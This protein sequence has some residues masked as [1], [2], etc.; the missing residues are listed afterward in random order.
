[1]R[2]VARGKIVESWNAWDMLELLQ[3]IGIVPKMDATKG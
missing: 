2:G 3:Q 1:M